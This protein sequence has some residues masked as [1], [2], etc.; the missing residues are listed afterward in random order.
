MTFFVFSLQP[1]SG[2]PFVKKRDKH[3]DFKERERLR[4]PR[5]GFPAFEFFLYNHLNLCMFS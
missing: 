1:P 2:Y 5:N 3:D 4:V